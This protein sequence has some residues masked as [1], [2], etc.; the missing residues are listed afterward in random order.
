MPPSSLRIELPAYCHS[1]QVRVTPTSTIRDVKQEIAKACPGSPSPDG[2]RL[3]W[4]GRFLK[5]DETV[6]LLWKTSEEVQVIHLA[7]HPSAW[8]TLP[9][10]SPPLIALFTLPR[11]SPSR[12]SA[13]SQQSFTYLHYLHS[14]SLSVLSCGAVPLPTV[15]N[16]NEL[17]VWRSN[18]QDF[19]RSR[20]WQWPAIYNQPFPSG[21]PE[22][23][24]ENRGLPYL[25]LVS[26]DIPPTPPQTH[27]LEVLSHTFATLSMV[28]DPSL[29]APVNPSPYPPHPFVAATD[30]NQHLQQLGLPALRAAQNQ[31]LNPNPV[32]ANP[33]GPPGVPAPEIRA[34]PARAL[35]IPLMF[36]AF[37]A[38]PLLGLALS[39]YILY[40]TWN[41]LHVV[42][43]DGNLDRDRNANANANAAGGAPAAPGAPAAQPAADGFT[44]Q[45]VLDRLSTMNLP[46]E[47]A[48]L[49]ADAPAPAPAPSLV[50]QA[51][52]FVTLFL[53]TLHPAAWDRRRT[54]LRRREGR[55]RT[56]VNAREAA[57]FDAQQQESARE[58]RA[59]QGEEEP[60][61][62]ADE[63]AKR[64]AREQM[65]QR[66]ERRPAWLREY[67]QRVQFT[68]WV[69]DP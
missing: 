62:S 50:H 34:I 21:S 22:P 39:L 16:V 33:M 19:H 27:A 25:Q 68:E 2:Q 67:V 30:V 60:A 58:H 11:L 51:K 66:H 1:F 53:L 15:P 63:A 49:D 7:V 26:P 23:G 47:D 29:Y 20:G 48:I 14:M 56:E 55:V 17:E 61:V 10:A 4:Q 45:A 41:A 9:H 64:R 59:A 13:Q 28:N 46:A 18:A 40:E 42:L 65:V 36:I 6:E 3:V 38:R 57:A 35:L 8:R 37:R 12:P 31:G 52:T 24:A 32:D 43:R 5:D 44:T 54:A 69:D